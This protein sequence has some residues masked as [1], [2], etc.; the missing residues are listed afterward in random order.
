MPDVVNFKKPQAFRLLMKKLP[1]KAAVRESALSK[2]NSLFSD[3][4]AAFKENPK[5]SDRKV[6]IALRTAQRARIAV[7]AAFKKRF[8]KYCSA[9]WMPG[10]T[11][12][13]RLQKQK[14]VYYCLACRHY[15]RHPYV[16]EKK[17]NRKKRRSA[18]SA[19]V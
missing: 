3:A 12:R 13:V 5:L 15:S 18:S 9:Y 16:K 19:A 7:P 1:D 10:S 4:A 8:C 11:V 2:I 6:R 17:A 14:V